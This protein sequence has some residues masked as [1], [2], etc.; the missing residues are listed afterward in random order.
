MSRH[1]HSATLD[2]LQAIHNQHSAIG[3]A[4]ANL[5]RHYAGK[6]GGAEAFEL[7]ASPLLSDYRDLLDSY[8][9]GWNAIAHVRVHPALLSGR[10]QD[11]VLADYVNKEKMQTIRE[12]CARDFA[13][14]QTRF[15]NLRGL[16]SAVAK[17][18][19]E[20]AAEHEANE[21]VA[22]HCLTV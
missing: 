16:L 9:A 8:E 21:C 19:D 10:P 6:Q 12:T 1:Y 18:A 3:V 20:L 11:K 17:G 2:L 22:P 13:D 4:I 7:F 14:L 5:R 15:Q